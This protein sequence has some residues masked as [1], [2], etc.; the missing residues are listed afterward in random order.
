MDS[1]KFGAATGTK[2]RL[3]TTPKRKITYAVQ[4]AALV[5]L[6]LS[7]LAP[8]SAQQT[9]GKVRGVV[10]DPNGAVVAGAKITI[11][12]KQTNNTFTTQ[13][14]GE[15]EYEFDN[16]PVGDYTITVEAT[17][18]KTLNLSNVRVVLNQTTDVPTNLVVGG[19][20]E[21]IEIS[22]AGAELVQTTTTDLSKNFNER[23]AVDLAQTAAGPI[24]GAG[25]NN[26]ALLAP[27]VVSS[28]G[29][30][31]GTGGSVGGQRP[32][33][34]DFIVDGVDNNDKTVTGPQVYVSP[35]TVSEFTLLQNNYSA[36]YGRSTGGQFITVTKSGTNEFHGTAFSF[37]RNRHLNA[38][39]TLDKQ[40]GLTRE[41]NPRSDYGRFGA[42]VGGPI[43]KDKLFF[44][45]SYERTQS[46]NGAGVLVQAPTA[47]GFTIL[48][49]LPGLS[50]TNL[51]IFDKF[52]PVAAT[53]NA[54]T[55]TVAGTTI[56]IG[57]VAVP[58]PA[59]VNQD[60]LVANF[61]YTQSESTQHHT[62]YIYNRIRAI[63]S[64]ATLPFFFVL[65]PQNYH[66]F[67]YTMNH[68]F[69]SR[70]T[71]ELRLAYRRRD[72]DTPVTEP[73]FPGLDRFPNIGLNDLGIN[74]GP[75]QNGPQS[76]IEN[77]YQ[78][79]DNVSYLVANHSMKFG[80][81]IR[82]II[83]P[84]D[85]LQRGRGD[86]EYNATDTFLRDISGELLNERSVGSGFY[87]GNEKLLFLF[88]QDDWRFRE[89]LTFNLGVNYSFQQ[90][91]A[92]AKQQALNAI[93]SV[94]G[95]IDFRE[96]RAQKK[97]FAPRI[98][99]AYSPKYQSGF[100]S[101]I[102][103]TENQSSIRAGFSMAYDILFDN[104]FGLSRPPQINTTI[105]VGGGIPN[106]LKNGGIPPTLPPFNTP[107]DARAATGAFIPDLQEPY[108][109]TYTL[110]FQRQFAKN[111]GLELRYL[112]TR[113]V[114]L[115]TQS[116][117]NIQS[118]VTPSQ[119]LPTFL[120]TP[121]AAQLAG[122]TLN[123]GTLENLNPIVPAF[124]AAGFN[125]NFLTAFPSNGA[126]S[127]NAFSAQLTRRFATGWQGTAAYTWSHLIDNSTAE[128]FST[129]LSPRRVQDF[130]NVGA[131]K[132]DSALDHRHRFA[133]S[134][135]YDLPFFTKS[136]NWT[137]RTFAG[138]W[139]L[140]G[141][142]TFESGEKA[143]IRS[144]LDSNLNL[145]TAGD[146]T[147]I[148]PAGIIGTA[149]TV[150]AIN[151]AG[152]TVP[153]GDPSTVAYVANVPNAQYIQ[154]G[155]GALAD[156]GRNTLQLPGI[157]NLDFSIF[158]NFAIKE[159]MKLQFRVDMYNAFNHAQYTPG[160]A[161]S[162]DLTTTT[163]GT[164]Q[165]LLQV[166]LNPGLFNR[167]DL[168]FSNHPRVL[169]MALRFNF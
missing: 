37:F 64:N 46:N 2:D 11:T 102:F 70:L 119:F 74:I 79:I 75:D 95:L 61:D 58:S 96:P 81:D 82:F 30:G 4:L 160:T 92:G 29:V 42:N 47:A 107:A 86:Y 154:A 76:T 73:Q 33:N 162:V 94:P 8:V 142:L 49:A 99:V 48:N 57:N 45:G 16:L 62:R 5:T 118:I 144:G 36:E 32:R 14:S 43:I 158:K 65:A 17:N 133:L 128:V 150:H 105:D 131:E 38:M 21:T 24:G 152:A 151:K 146:R 31:V 120:S 85:F 164:V 125:N 109:I 3:A 123:A 27:N 28:G 12:N 111:Y 129:L 117:L 145:D 108:A 156:A 100:L 40:A 53:N 78:I 163:S 157:N 167:P 143:T 159:T 124:D 1:N 161:N 52:V 39:D 106:F 50:A 166:G 113:G 56:P 83:S 104:L 115:V 6:I 19:A 25:I 101:K 44:F 87:A 13:S 134:T 127:Y 72:T 126:S 97:N 88:A 67:S 55:I 15:G 71:N 141:T 91:P 93:A 22:A 9:F 63:D 121:T 69:S 135:T 137:A 114:R 18:F 26:L 41:T 54:G 132:A 51:G 7:L 139:S 84:Q 168:V 140:A 155:L 66:L 20:G 147:I 77:N 130:Q 165:S 149:S 110:D 136:S 80:G 59:F 153:M 23:Q 10:K 60:N 103:G 148:N 35:E 68:V 116:R 122:L 34:N 138:G 90:V 169:Q 89:N 112:G 98:G